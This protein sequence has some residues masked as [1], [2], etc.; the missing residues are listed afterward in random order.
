VD[1][2]SGYYNVGTGVGISLL[3][4]IKGIIQVFGKYNAIEFCPDKPDAPQYIMDITPA[5]LELGY[6]PKYDYLSSLK[7]LKKEMISKRLYRED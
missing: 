2:S 4:Q 7:D 5:R 3:D 6:E 1:R